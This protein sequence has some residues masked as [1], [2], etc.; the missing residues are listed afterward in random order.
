MV[1]QERAIHT[2]RIILEA[3]AEM[4]NELGYDATTIGGLI[5]RIQLTRGGLYFHF[6]TKE[7]LARGVLD[8]AV[9]ME[10][11]APQDF[12]LQEWVDLALLLAYRLPREPLLG[13]AIRLS[14]DIKARGLLGTR[15]PDWISV[16]QE[17]LTEAKERGELLVHVD[18]GDT[19]RLLVGAW[20]GVQ[21]ITET[22]PDRDLSEE[23]SCLFE[24][25]LPNIASAGVLAKLDTS[26]QRAERLLRA[27]ESS[28]EP[29]RPA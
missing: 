21:Q 27:A 14:V 12:K 7:Q 15:W 9:T 18:P 8:E 24:L 6:T 28:A 17:L 23:I 11:L 4:F 1:R 16:G 20:T 25:V 19:A 22:L 29:S 3:A 13:A 26:P 5:E 2:R 10:G